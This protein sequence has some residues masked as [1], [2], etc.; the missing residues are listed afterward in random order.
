VADLCGSKE[1]CI[2]WRPDPS[3]EGILLSGTS[4]AFCQITLDTCY[5]YNFSSGLNGNVLILHRDLRLFD[6]IAAINSSCSSSSSSSNS[7]VSHVAVESL[8]LHAVRDIEF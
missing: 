8:S 5:Y 7:K 1:P 2:R 4:T 6:T 3:W